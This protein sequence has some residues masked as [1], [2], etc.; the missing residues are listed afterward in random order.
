[1]RWL[2]RY[3]NQNR[4][5]IIITVAII[6]FII[7][8]IQLTNSFL[9]G[10]ERE[11][12]K[13]K[14][15][16]PYKPTQSVITGEIVSPEITDR[17]TE[18][19]DQFVKYCNNKEYERA[20]EILSD[21][22]KEVVF[23]NSIDYFKRNYCDQIFNTAKTY[24]IDLW[25]N[26][27][28]LYTYQVK[29]YEDNL[30]ATGGVNISNNIEDYITIT[31]QN[32]E[33]RLNINGF[34]NKEEINKSNR[35][36]NVEISINSKIIYK[37]YET[38]DITIK[39]YTR[40]TILINNGQESQKICLL[41]NNKVEYMSFIHEIP[42][43]RLTL[44]SAYK[45]DIQIRFNKIYDLNRNIEKVR[46]Q[47]IILNYEDYVRNQTKENLEVTTIDVKI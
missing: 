32:N 13:Q 45:K 18:I 34:I 1:M 39:N 7:I 4:K 11:I 16:D 19:L 46:F 9:K 24:S 38:Y 25:V 47:D 5:Q 14:N 6:A 36:D 8:I 21:N 29:Y 2:I 28:N 41:D 31:Q 27:G 22:C 33:D 17:N 35:E 20:F 15:A 44:K 42:E 12:D 40:N 43:E 23:N 26:N 10:R 30:L 3:W 37:N